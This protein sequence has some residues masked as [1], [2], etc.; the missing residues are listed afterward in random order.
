M[1]RER[2]ER[3][4]QHFL[5]FLKFTQFISVKLES[6]RAV[7]ERKNVV[8]LILA[9]QQTHNIYRAL[10]IIFGYFKMYCLVLRTYFKF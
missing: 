2:Y 9:L 4:I 10:G 7:T 8:I 1:C 6:V 5:L 3:G